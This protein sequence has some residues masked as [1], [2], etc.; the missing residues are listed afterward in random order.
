MKLITSLLDYFTFT[1]KRHL[2]R[3]YFDRPI[4]ESRY[5]RINTIAMV[6]ALAMGALVLDR[7]W[8][9]LP[10]DSRWLLI[11]AMFCVFGV[12]ERAIREHSRVQQY[13]QTLPPDQIPEGILKELAGASNLVPY[14][15][16]VVAFVL[17]CAL[18]LAAKHFQTALR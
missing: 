13:L 10:W 16:Y 17:I 15:L 8:P 1:T 5:F 9:A 7:F 4:F 18:G 6:C 11:A 3:H 2:E 14:V 12:W